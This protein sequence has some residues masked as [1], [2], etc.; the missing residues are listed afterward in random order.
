MKISIYLLLSNMMLM[1]CDSR[2]KQHNTILQHTTLGVFKVSIDAR[3][4]IDQS[5][6]LSLLKPQNQVCCRTDCPGASVLLTVCF[7]PGV[8]KSHTK[9]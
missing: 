7:L 2:T 4:L 8:P 1:S 9:L 3:L 5:A 6:L